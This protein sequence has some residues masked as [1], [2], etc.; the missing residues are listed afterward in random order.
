MD[1]KPKSELDLYQMIDCISS[2]NN[3]DTHIKIFRN[4]IIVS[5]RLVRICMRCG[6]G[7]RRSKTFTIQ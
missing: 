2:N 4:S 7:N 3:K 5:N 6:L 1:L